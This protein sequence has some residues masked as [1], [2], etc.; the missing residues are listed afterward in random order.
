MKGLFKARSPVILSIPKI[1]TDVEI[2]RRISLSDILQEGFPI[3]GIVGTFGT[4]LRR[5]RPD[6][7]VTLDRPTR[8]VQVGRVVTRARGRHALSRPPHLSTPPLVRSG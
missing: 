8:S 3:P 1:P 7:A 5:A 4:G 6:T 2:P